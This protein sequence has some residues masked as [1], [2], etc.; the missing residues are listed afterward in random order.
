MSL[1]KT[2]DTVKDNSSNNQIISKKIILKKASIVDMKVYIKSSLLGKEKV[3]SIPNAQQIN[4]GLEENG[5]SLKELNKELIKISYTKLKAITKKN[6][7]FSKEKLKAEVE[8]QLSLTKKEIKKSS[9]KI[10]ESV[11]KKILKQIF[12][13]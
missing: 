9:E 11:E 10:K 3:I 5:I 4:I 12:N 8:K 2:K 6:T 7:G 13:N 1:P